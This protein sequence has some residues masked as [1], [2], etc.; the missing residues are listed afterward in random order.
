MLD[1]L[2]S[3]LAG[4]L[5]F[6]LAT[7]LSYAIICLGLNLQWGQT[8]LFNVGVAG[9]VAIGAYTSAIL[10]TPAGDAHLGGFGLPIVVGW[11]GAMLVSAAATAFDGLITLRL[12]ADYLAITTFG[13]AVSIHLV[14]LNAQSI[15]G[16]PFGI[17]RKS[18][19]LNSSHR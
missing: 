11:L 19:R 6:F 12:R 1:F 3:G 4:Y 8:G 5:A 13:I 16:G 14:A 7:A 10:T 17:D 9:F 18:T 15:T 2:T